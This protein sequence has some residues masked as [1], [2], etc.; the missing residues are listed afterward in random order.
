MNAF[1]RILKIQNINK[2]CINILIALLI[3]VKQLFDT[4]HLCFK[5][6]TKKHNN[7]K[8]EKQ[9]RQQQKKQINSQGTQTVP[10]FHGSMMYPRHQH[11]EHK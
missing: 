4:T 3:F 10:W 11:S 7:R 8:I 2:N 9:Q 1:Q 6:K 5:K